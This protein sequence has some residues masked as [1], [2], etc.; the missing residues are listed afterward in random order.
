MRHTHSLRALLALYVAALP[1]CG[2][3]L[4]LRDGKQIDGTV[5]GATARQ[6]EF[7]PSTGKTLKVPIDQVDSVK[8]SS[9]IVAAAPKPTPPPA[10]SVV[11]PA[12]TEFRVRTIDAID[13]DATKAG[14][15]FR[16]ALDDPMMVGGNVIVPRGA[17][18]TLVASKVQ[19]GGKMKGSDLVELKVNS[20]VV[21]GRVYPVVTTVSESKSAGEGKKTGRKIAGG[22]GLGA[23][24]GGIAGGGTGAAIGALAGGAA[25]TIVAAS[26]QPHLKIPSESRI[27]FQLTADVRVQ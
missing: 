2:D 7:L 6:V 1:L 16:A 26:G 18:V 19:Q 27:T 14:A 15:K 5:V 22:A 21:R 11:L 23:I 8:F 4:I 10:A 25:G 9:P 13:V 17:D 3:T 24:I 20:I 12:G